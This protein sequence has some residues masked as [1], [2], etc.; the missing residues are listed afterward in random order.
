MERNGNWLE[1]ATRYD[2]YGV[3]KMN[4]RLGFL[5]AAALASISN[6]AMAH[7]NHTQVVAASDSVAHYVLQPSHALPIVGVCAALLVAATFLLNR[8]KANRMKPARIRVE[9]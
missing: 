5:A 3:S 2:C 1:R 6:A 8:R 4:F 7:P 9:R